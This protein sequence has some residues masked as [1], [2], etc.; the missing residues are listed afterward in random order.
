M[1]TIDQKIEDLNKIGLK[2]WLIIR[3]DVVDHDAYQRNPETFAPMCGRPGD[4]LPK[5]M[6]RF[7]LMCD[8]FVQ[9]DAEITSKGLKILSNKMFSADFP[10]EQAFQFQRFERGEIVTWA[11]FKKHFIAYVT[12]SVM[13][14]QNPRDYELKYHPAFNRVDITPHPPGWRKTLQKEKR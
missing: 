5:E 7:R 9:L 4:P 6:K 8:G 11:K 1:K 2:S 13:R 12:M 3:C 10:E 14:V